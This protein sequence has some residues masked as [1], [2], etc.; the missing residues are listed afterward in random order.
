MDN[1]E[2]IYKEVAGELGISK[3]VIKSVA[4]SQF[5]LVAN[6]FRAKKLDAIR[7]QY[8]GTFKVK[9]GRLKFLSQEAQAHIKKNNNGA[10][11]I[12]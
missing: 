3:E 4:D 2:K 6:T 8:L 12:I 9:P 7:L 11:K 1:L 5:S 10:D